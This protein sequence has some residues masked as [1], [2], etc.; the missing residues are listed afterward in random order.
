[1]RPKKSSSHDALI[2]AVPIVL[3]RAA[4]R[5]RVDVVLAEALARDVERAVDLRAVIG[6]RAAHRRLRTRK[7][8][9]RDLQA[10]VAGKRTLDQLAQARIA[11]TLPPVGG[12]IGRAGLRVEPDRGRR[13]RRRD[14]RDPGAARTTGERQHQRRGKRDDH[15]CQRRQAAQ[16]TVRNRPAAL[17]TTSCLVRVRFR[18]PAPCIHSC[19]GFICL[20]RYF[21]EGDPADVVSAQSASR[22]ASPVSYMRFR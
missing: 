5:W 18:Q 11:E 16:G 7:A 22:S 15:R 4:E 8:R 10:R 13:D 1:L 17:R 12:D 19:L 21:G 9:L 20:G 3:D 2:C 14:R 6:L